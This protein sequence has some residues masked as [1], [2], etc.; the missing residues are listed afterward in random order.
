[1]R[2]GSIIGQFLSGCV[3]LFAVV[4]F[5]FLLLHAAP[6][7]PAIALTGA[8][9][10]ATLESLTEI[11][12]TY[13][14]DQ[15]LYL[16]FFWYLGNVLRGDFGNSI[17]F[18]APVAGLILERVPPT[19]LL[20]GS[21][22]VFAIL[23]GLLFGTLSA[24]KP[25]GILSHMISILS[26]IGFSAPVFWTGII[27]LLVFASWIPLFPVQGMIDPRTPDGF[28]AQARDVLYHL[29]LPALTLGSVYLAQYS[30]LART[31]MME[32]LSAD[33]I[34]TARAKGASERSVVYRHALRN[35]ILP[36]VTVAGVQVSHLLAGAVLVETVFGWPGMGRL[37]YESIL[38]RDAPLMLG[39]LFFTALLV[40]VANVLTDIV[41]RAV[42]PRIR[43]Q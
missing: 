1:M 15:P 4:L 39:I 21:S 28:F 19:I 25:S 18:N 11:R 38:R 6:G 5:N 9:G 13:G 27:L 37:A 8:T 29:V 14:L 30:R 22:L 33:Y 34:R 31:S 41:Y 20:V 17:Y 10:G 24:Q 32:A 16:Q 26:L 42:D 2:T 43:A 35:A 7:D 12:H 23:A 40:I 3:L 36:I